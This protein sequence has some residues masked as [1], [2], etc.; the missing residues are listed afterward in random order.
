MLLRVIT[1]V[2]TAHSYLDLL[3]DNLQDNLQE[4][5]QFTAFTFLPLMTKK[6]TLDWAKF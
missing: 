3:Q 6:L 2:G 5:T 4:W 1:E